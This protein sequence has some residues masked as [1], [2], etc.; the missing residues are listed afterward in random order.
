MT[1]DCDPAR[2]DHP[3]AGVAGPQPRGFA[4]RAGGIVALARADRGDAC[5]R[6]RGSVVILAM[7][8]RVAFAAKPAGGL[9]TGSPVCPPARTS[10][11]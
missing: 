6:V 5:V 7:V 11:R 10:R 3:H 1:H 4:A 9:A 2:E 8:T